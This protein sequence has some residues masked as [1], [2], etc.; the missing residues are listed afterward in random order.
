MNVF[1]ELFELNKK[2]QNDEEWLLAVDNILYDKGVDTLEELIGICVE[3]EDE[4]I[5][6]A[7]IDEGESIMLEK[8]QTDLS[9]FDSEEEG[10]Y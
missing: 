8:D 6:Y 5:I 4:S 7:L 3:E 9:W 2:L 10:S 1:D